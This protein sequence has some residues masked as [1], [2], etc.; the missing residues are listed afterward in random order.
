MVIEICVKHPGGPTRKRGTNFLKYFWIQVSVSRPRMR[1]RHQWL[2]PPKAGTEAPCHHH[3]S[4]PFWI[5]VRGTTQTFSWQKGG[6]PENWADKQQPSVGS[7]F[8]SA[9]K[10]LTVCCHP[11]LDIDNRPPSCQSPHVSCY[12]G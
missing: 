4:W 6:Q 5:L 9:I 1:H 10:T 2:A 11:D 3:Q 12:N 7:I 8:Y